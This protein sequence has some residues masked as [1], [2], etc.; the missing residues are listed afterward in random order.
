MKQLLRKTRTTTIASA[1]ILG[2]AAFLLTC[3]T[4]DELPGGIIPPGNSLYISSAIIASAG[5]TE[6]TITTRALVPVTKGSLGI[7]R[8]KGTGYASTLDN[9]EYTY[10]SDVLGW[11]AATA[12]DTLFL[13][14]DDAD[15]CAY[16]PYNVALN[17]IDKTGI[18]LMSG[19]YTG[20][21][22]KHDPNDICY[23]T[24]R[25]LNGAN[26]VTS[27][28]MKHAMAMLEFKITKDVDYQGDCRVTSVSLL[29][30]NLIR[31][32]SIDISNGTY[33]TTPV[34]GA[35]AYN[36]GADADGILIGNAASTT[37]ALLVPFTP[38]TDGLTLSFAVND[39]PVT[40]SIG[41]DKLPK[42]EAGYRYTVNLTMK[43]TSMKVTG[44]EMMPWE[45]TGV[46]GDD[47]TWYP[48]EDAIK[49]DAP[50]HIASYDWAWSNLEKG[51]AGYALGSYQKLAGSLWAWNVLEPMTPPVKAGDMP[52][53]NT[54]SYLYGQDPCSKLSP[55]GTWTLPN[56]HQIDLLFA[57][58][59]VNAA[60][61]CWFGTSTVISASEDNGTCLFLPANHLLSYN[62]FASYS[63]LTELNKGMGG[64]WLCEGN[65]PG[66]TML[67]VGTHAYMN[68]TA[69]YV[70]EPFS[71]S[72]V[73]YGGSIR[74]VQKPRETITLDG[75][76]WAMGNLV[77]KDDGT[78]VIDDFQAAMPT[79]TG[80]ST[81]T[82][83][84]VDKG[85]HF[86]WNSLDRK[87]MADNNSYDYDAANDPCAK[88]APAGTW[89][90][91]TKEEFDKAVARGQV[92][93]TYTIRDLTVDGFYLG[94]NTAPA[95]GGGDEFLFLPIAGSGDQHSYYDTSAQYWTSTEKEGSEGGADAYKF[96]ASMFSSTGSVDVQGKSYPSSV[97]CVKGSLE[98]IYTLTSTDEVKIGTVTY[99]RTNLNKDFTF[100]AEPWI[101]GMMNGTDIDYWFW[102][103]RDINVN[104][105][106]TNSSND[107]NALTGEQ[108]DPCKSVSGGGWIMPT[109]AQL[110]ALVK[111][112]MPAG[113]KVSINGETLT[114]TGSCGWVANATK[115]TAGT[116][117]YDSATKN[118]LFIPAAGTED[119]AGNVQGTGS[120]GIIHVS[121]GV[122]TTTTAPLYMSS[123]VC[124][125]GYPG[126]SYRYTGFSIRCVKK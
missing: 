119:T 112:V 50:I 42:V 40:V 2:A 22:A 79:F 24:D 21:D 101:S 12:A 1:C 107:W 37:A 35:V 68:G 3:C 82:W 28:E 92:K 52:S 33:D 113:E 4:Q 32:S 10:K 71:A 115:S 13:N 117:F 111:K 16:Y 90:T 124:G 58:D 103:R 80:S 43:A 25:T 18:P 110:K 44:V 39:M 29:N 69:P 54:G 36:P 41:T 84:D 100:E 121:D 73:M 38:D 98:K 45:E 91:P 6:T 15:V 74:C 34:K 14:G 46:G 63:W 7:F 95:K 55:V 9:L 122:N 26:R 106:Y 93:G 126:W 78:Y 27:F 8:S 5:H 104:G 120:R 64:Y 60:T 57:T 75:V 30:P 48:K 53:P 89:R 105:T 94:T 70:G 66:I 96:A 47:Y 108:E 20:T 123:G 102:G 76:E 51:D 85:Y 11:Q 59:H 62:N 116:V 49:L 86:T 87:S 67:V 31:V 81:A 118:V 65:D 83:A 114:V 88:V 97:R 56:K 17:L 61:G 72:N 19:K 23:D 125:I 109:Q 77:K 99:A